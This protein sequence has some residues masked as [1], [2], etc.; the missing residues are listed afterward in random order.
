MKQQ[1]SIQ[2]MSCDHCV[3]RVEKAIGQ[4][5]GVQKVKVNLK[6]EKSVVKFD[7]TQLAPET[8]VEAVNELGYQAEVL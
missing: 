6:K 1:F 5:E 8:I 2:G 7:D 4:L 3:Q